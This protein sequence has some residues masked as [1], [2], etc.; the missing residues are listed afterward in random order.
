MIQQFFWR[1]T[2]LAKTAQKLQIIPLG[3]LG[4]IGK[5]MTVIR[6][7]DEILVIDAGLMFPDEDMLGIDLV[8]PDISYLIENKDKIK[9]I[10][11]THGHEDHIGALPYVLKKI[12]VPVYGTR[13]TLGIL[14]GRLKENG[15]D[16]SNLHSVMQGDIINIGCFSVGFIRVNHSIP[17]AVGLSIKTP[18]GM[19]VHTGDFKLDYTPI[20]GKMT[21]FRR[22]SDL[23]NRGVLVLMADSTNSEREG[24]TPSERTVGAAFDK[25]FHNARG[26]IIVATFSSNV[27]R[28]QQVIDTAVR[29]KRHVAV[30]GRSMVNVVNISLE[31]GY[32]TAP[33]GTLVD[34]DEIHNYRMEQMVII[35]TGSQ[36]E[37]M[38]ALTRMSMS[39]HRKVGIVP[40][41][42]VIISAT[43]IPGNEKLVSK[44]IDNLMKLGANVIYGRNQGIHVSGHASREELKLM[45]NLVRPK[46]FIPVHG[47]YHHLVQH[48]RLARELGMPKEN[49]FISENGQILEFTRDKGQVAGKVTAGMVMVDGLGVGDVGNIVLRDRRQLSQDGILIVVVTM[50]KQTHRVVAGPDIVSRGFVY[51]RESEALMDE[52]TARVRQA[53]ARCEDEKVKEW[54]AIKSNVRDALGRYLFE[55]TRRRPMILPIIMEI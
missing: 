34:I 37:P 46:F 42:T 3:G 19:I 13:L 29:Y 43:P 17:D 35:T 45:H 41:D 7:D 27:H 47:E 53:L 8:I 48:A 4:E 6:V 11:L 32:I 28:I 30:L 22:F 10:V 36:G 40:G 16:S 31:L 49:I 5:N 54:A 44:T 52:A 18:V 20:D 55:K 39:D 24:H 51:V 12:N 21:D 9:A 50:N 33:E 2:F 38:S 25:A 1:C 14:E 26:R 23:G 15:V